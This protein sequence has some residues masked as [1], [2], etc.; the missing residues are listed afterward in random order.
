MASLLE[1][2]R[3]SS[4]G[5]TLGDRVLEVTSSPLS[6]SPAVVPSVRPDGVAGRATE[7]PSRQ[8]SEGIR[9]AESLLV[10]VEGASSLRQRY[11]AGG[12]VTSPDAYCI[13]EIL[14]KPR[15]RVMTPVVEQTVEPVWD[16]TL[17]L[18]DF[19]MG[20][21]LE[22]SV[23]DRNEFLLKDEYLGRALV[24]SL[25][26]SNNR[27]SGEVQLDA[28][29]SSEDSL[30]GSSADSSRG[31]LRLTMV[32]EAAPARRRQEQELPVQP[33]REEEAAAADHRADATAAWSV[34]DSVFAGADSLLSRA[35]AAEERH[36]EPVDS[37]TE[38]LAAARDRAQ[39]AAQRVSAWQST[40]QSPPSPER[41]MPQAEVWSPRCSPAAAHDAGITTSAWQGYDSR[42]RDEVLT[43]EA[44]A[45]P[46]GH[47][48]LGGLQDLP[49]FG[50]TFESPSSVDYG[51]DLRH[52]AGGASSS[53]SL[54]GL[55]ARSLADAYA[56]GSV[57]SSP[58]AM[59]SAK[60]SF[61]PCED[62][63][64]PGLLDQSKSLGT[65]A[66]THIYDGPVFFE[67]LDKA[68]AGDLS[69]RDCYVW[70]RGLGWC[71]DDP[72]LDA[73]LETLPRSH[74]LKPAQDP[75][76]ELLDISSRMDPPGDF[77]APPKEEPPPQDRWTLDALLSGAQAH[78]HLCGPDLKALSNSVHMLTRGASSSG[79]M[80]KEALKGSLTAY[81][82]EGGLTEAEFDELL[83]LCGV[84]GMA[85][86]VQTDSLLQSVTE[87]IC[88]PRAAT[89]HTRGPGGRKFGGPCLS[90]SR[91]SP[92][93]ASG[94]LTPRK[95][96]T[97]R[98]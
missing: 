27:F 35:S 78:R 31:S 5:G 51:D 61:L 13:C 69:R 14:G 90:S 93:Q 56:A 15:S 17:T 94:R 36:M 79:P 41:L 82:H 43:P 85:R 62:R 98:A 57:E 84:P 37:V 63:L 29:R 70:F 25:D 40:V 9:A 91:G 60:T 7:L 4:G 26:F 74:H 38:C 16:C 11:M 53:T 95:P 30:A 97:P 66:A 71:L 48:M 23:Y 55:Q 20:D 28:R 64:Y 39:E 24:D 68:G 10:T 12:S 44:A 22:F 59:S 18:A 33:P 75:I 80:R 67:L 89:I 76:D 77:W 52:T 21:M 34:L 32:I 58:R 96:A 47:S 49:T 19:S 87:T 86:T 54:G 2:A 73:I 65:T 50:K 72:D 3:S 46:V 42:S 6:V 1:P 88:Q 81:A 45:S 8:R 83:E 92:Q